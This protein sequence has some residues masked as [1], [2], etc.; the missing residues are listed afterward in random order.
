MGP[1]LDR[2]IAQT[3]KEY[4]PEGDLLLS[5]RAQI[6]NQED[7]LHHPHN[8]SG[9]T[10]EGINMMRTRVMLARALDDTPTAE[11]Y[12]S[13]IGKA[14]TNL[15]EELWDSELGRFIYYKDPTDLRHLDGQ[16]QTFIYP[17]IWGIVDPLDAWT[18]M[19]HLRDRLMGFDGEIYCSNNF[20]NHV[21][22]TWGMQAGASQQPW[23]AFGLSAAGLRNETF[24][25]LRA[26]SRWVMSES[27]RGL[28]AGNFH[29]TDS[30]V[31]FSAGRRLCSVGCRSVIRVE[32]GQTGGHAEYITI[33]SGFMAGSESAFAKV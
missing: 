5:W 27:L 9:P 2:V 25:P 14:M 6:G 23:G 4:D 1:V 33:L 3:F 16:Y 12:E 21:A 32:A 17:L 7:Y 8:S 24:M 29:G 18:G 30:R 22:G 26:L 15:R 20:P 13:L 11:H 28:V 19:R 31:F 10:I